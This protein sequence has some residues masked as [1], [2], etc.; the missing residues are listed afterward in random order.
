[1]KNLKRVLPMLLVLV[2]VFA[3]AAGTTARAVLRTWLPASMPRLPTMFSPTTT[4]S[5][6]T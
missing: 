5:L 3:L 2:L 6:R 1:M 4:S